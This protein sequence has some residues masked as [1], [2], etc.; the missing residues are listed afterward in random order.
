MDQNVKTTDA[1][2]FATVNTG[3]GANELYD[4]DQD[5]KTTSNVKFTQTQVGGSEAFLTHAC[6]HIGNPSS[7]DYIHIDMD[8]GSLTSWANSAKVTLNHSYNNATA[9]CLF[10]Q[11]TWGGENDGTASDFAS[12]GQVAGGG[13]L[14]GR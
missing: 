13:E 12:F 2:T 7:N 10:V 3:Q 11:C 14:P 6:V 9:G 4:M 5:V 8:M 1:V